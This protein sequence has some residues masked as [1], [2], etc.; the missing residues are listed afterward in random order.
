MN[1]TEKERLSRE[2]RAM[3]KALS[4]VDMIEG[5]YEE[6]LESAAKTAAKRLDPSDIITPAGFH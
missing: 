6:W 3:F 1:E 4:D 5:T 2:C